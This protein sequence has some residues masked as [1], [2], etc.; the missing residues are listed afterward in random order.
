MLRTT[1]ILAAAAVVVIG[2]VLTGCG[3]DGPADPPGP[4]DKRDVPTVI[5]PEHIP[6]LPS[7]DEL[8][9][10]LQKG[11]DPTVPASE[12]VDMIQGSEADPELINRVADAAQKAEVT[13]TVIGVTDLGSGS[14]TA[15]VNLTI[16]G[17]PGPAVVP[18]VAENGTWKLEKSWACDIVTNMGQMQSPAC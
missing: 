2:L 18:L 5:T 3:P 15:D 7:I 9:A 6:R 4:S 16:K 17:Q 1:R 11:L 10:M 8:N 12:K 14:A 13:V